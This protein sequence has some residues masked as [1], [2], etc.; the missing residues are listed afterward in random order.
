L[1]EN[2]QWIWIAIDTTTKQV[3]AFYV[4][5]RSRKSDKQLWKLIPQAYRDHA[6]FATDDCEAYK[7][8]IPAAQHEVCAKGSGH[9]NII[10]RFNCALRRRVARLAPDALSFSKILSNH[11][12]G[13]S[14]HTF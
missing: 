1:Q 12:R 4:G 3:I 5:D 2:K 8:V 14:Q 10:E 11:R 7:G 9:A 13:S 6:T